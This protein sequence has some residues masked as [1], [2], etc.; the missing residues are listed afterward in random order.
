MFSRFRMD[1]DDFVDIMWENIAKKDRVYFHILK[2]NTKLDQGIKYDY[3]S[4]MHA[5]ENEF[6]KEPSVDSILPKKKG[7]IIGQRGGMSDNDALSVNKLYCK[8]NKSY[9]KQCVESQKG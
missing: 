9:Y 6:S 8:C 2:N 7:T 5:A 4:I 1:R 3:G